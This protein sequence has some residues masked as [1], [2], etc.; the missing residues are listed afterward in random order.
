MGNRVQRR[1]AASV[2]VAAAAVAGLVG[3]D[4]T[5]SFGASPKVVKCVGTADFC[6]ATISIAHG[7]SNKVVEVELTDTDFSRVGVRAI[8]S[9]SRG[10]FL[11]SNA[12]FMEGGSIYRFTLNAVSANPAHARIVLLFAA[13]AAAGG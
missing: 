9:G 4:V 8:P 3:F 11:I 5:P 1:V 7:L 6:G 13:G 12:S 2:L 10:A